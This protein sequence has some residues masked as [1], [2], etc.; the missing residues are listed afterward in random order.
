VTDVR[1]LNGIVVVDKPAGITSAGAVELV[2][3]RLATRRAGH[4]GTLDPIATGVLAVCVGEATKLAAFLQAEDKAYEVEAVLGVETDTL[5]REGHI[6]R[7][8]DVG[9]V[10]R[11]AVEAA[12][13]ARLGEQD[14]VPPMFSAIKQDGVRLHVHAR[15]GQVVERMPRR[16][17][18]DRFELVAWTPPRARF[19]IACGKGTYVRSLIADVGEALGCGAYVAELR[20]TRSGGFAIEDAHQI[21][22]LDAGCL[23]PMLGAAQLPIVR[24]PVAEVARV[25]S[26]VQLAAGP[27]GAPGEGRFQVAAEGDTLLAIAHVE[28]GKLVY[29]RVFTA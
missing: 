4:T 18:V 28:V 17:R 9:A 15:A 7:T 8:R 5:D 20:R 14:Q 21:D 16:V 1:T 12:A 27:L 22:A 11:E 23:R 24:V 19:A 10:S 26:G 13:A 2:R 29:D 25:R 6:T 3:R